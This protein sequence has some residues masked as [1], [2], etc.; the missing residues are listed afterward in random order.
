M[1]RLFIGQPLASPGSANKRVNFP[2]MQYMIL[3]CSPCYMIFRSCAML[4]LVNIHI[5][6]C[7]YQKKEQKI[8][9]NILN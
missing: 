6:Y 1:T 9:H 8:I 2:K 7:I 4:I 5:L 3:V